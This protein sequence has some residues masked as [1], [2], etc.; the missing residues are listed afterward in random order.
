MNVQCDFG[1]RFRYFFG[2]TVFI[3]TCSRRTL[4]AIN[5]Y[6][7][8]SGNKKVEKQNK[9][10]KVYELKKAQHRLIHVKM[11]SIILQRILSIFTYYS[12]GTTALLVILTAYYVTFKLRR[13]RMESLLAKVPGPAPLPIIGNLLEIS[14]G[15]DRN[16]N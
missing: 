7:L 4:T 16:I 8:L 2:W 12:P 6:I 3:Y 5:W 15:F 1:L 10:C 11:K 9:N 13:R 14:T